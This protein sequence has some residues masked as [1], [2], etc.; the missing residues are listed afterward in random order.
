M[1]FRPVAGGRIA[2]TASMLAPALVGSGSERI[3]GACMSASLRTIVILVMS[4]LMVA[5]SSSGVLA[6][7]SAPAFR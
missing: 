2:L 6:T 4:A 1:E 7:T 3:Y 5:A